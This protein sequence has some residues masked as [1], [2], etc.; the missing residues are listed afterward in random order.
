MAH[1]DEI[2]NYV[3]NN[4]LE[5]LAFTE[6]R[7]T[8]DI[9]DVE[10]QIKGYSH[11]RCN[12]E[13]R[14]TGA[15]ICYVKNYVNYEVKLN[16]STD[17]VLW[18]LAIEVNKC[19]IVIVYRSPSSSTAEFLIHFERIVEDIQAL[20]NDNIYIVGDLNID[21]GVSSFYEDKLIKLMKNIG[22]SQ[23]VKDY[24]RITDISKTIIDLVFTNDEEAQVEV[25]RTPKITDHDII[26]LSVT[27]SSQMNNLN[28]ETY[29]YKFRDLKKINETNIVQI[30]SG[31]KWLN[32][33]IDHM[34]DVFN[35]NI[36]SAVDELA[37]IQTRKSKKLM[38][39]WF[40]EET[41]LLIERRDF[42]Y[43]Q[44]RLQS[45]EERWLVYKELRNLVTTTI[46]RKKKLYYENLIDQNKN[47]SKAMWRA[48]KEVLG[49]KGKKNTISKIYIGNSLVTDEEQIAERFNEYF[50]TSIDN[51]VKNKKQNKTF[52]SNQLEIEENN[53]Q[54]ANFRHIAIDDI[55][56]IIGTLKKNN[57]IDGIDKKII[58][59][60]MPVIGKELMNI[61]NKSIDEGKVPDKWKG[62]LVIPVPKVINTK[63]CE[64]HRPINMQ[65]VSEKTM[66]VFIKEQILDHVKINNILI[67]NQSG[68]R[69]KHS[70]ESSIQLVVSK[71][72]EL[73]DQGKTVLTVFIDFKRAFETIDRKKLTNKLAK[74][75]IVGSAN[76]W[77]NDYL[78]NRYQQTK[79][80]EHISSKKEVNFG[81]PQGTVLGP[82]LF[83][84]YINDIVTCLDSSTIINLFADDTAITVFGSGVEEVIEKMQAELKS[85][86]EWLSSNNLFVNTQK[87]KVMLFNKKNC[88]NI[89]KIELFG[90]QLEYVVE[91]KYL[92]LIIDNQLNFSK[93]ANYVIDKVNKKINFFRRLSNNLSMYTRVTVYKSI[94]AP[95]FDYCPTILFYLN[96]KEKNSLQKL[97]NR[98]MRVIL[99][100]NRYVRIKD[101]LECLQFMSVDQRLVYMNL[102]FIFKMIH[103]LLPEYMAEKISFV[104][105]VH[106]YN[107]RN[108]CDIYVPTVKKTSTQNS[109]F[110]KGLVIY[111]SL[112]HNIKNIN[113][114]NIFKRNI[115]QYVKNNY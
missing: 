76:K 75:G 87:T 9:N 108:A 35:N 43:N 13:N 72:K 45:T 105:D 19:L 42:A 22:L 10:L 92:G 84:L 55:K 40:D 17:K 70:C 107:T 21:V 58:E 71:W 48:I 104:N 34:L 11:V 65:P 99:K 6:A 78:S 3:E 74:Y 38:N 23:K 68:F 49:N 100:T 39:K 98:A 5:I 31:K 20:S 112:P 50:V 77:V 4:E 2:K 79:I 110:H 16:I 33:E 29:Y 86:E 41:K 1:I 53:L 32:G 8:E 97:Q 96:E 82:L 102:L 61:I 12:S 24:T 113:S 46:R 26:S 114:I 44:A 111:N 109:L 80:G 66:E 37:P 106:N 115:S 15:V 59:I 73:I 30:L 88:E 94:I 90:N 25:R 64:E 63:K 95:H 14:Y 89:N 57:S 91:C 54:L 67:P 60:G 85:L 47:N 83:I 62:S 101:M 36:I 81:V 103:N 69:D 52:T 18:L 93:H 51:I 56:K 27:K 7:V 28:K